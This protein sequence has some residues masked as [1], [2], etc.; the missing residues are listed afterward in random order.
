MTVLELTCS[1]AAFLAATSGRFVAMAEWRHSTLTKQSF[2]V[3]TENTSV[4]HSRRK[5]I[6]IVKS[7][8]DHV[9]FIVGPAVG[10]VN[11]Y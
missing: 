10:G 11:P 5:I 4:Y 6:G 2:G 7:V 8:G 9:P 3:S 1:R